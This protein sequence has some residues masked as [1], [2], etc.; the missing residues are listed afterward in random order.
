[1]LATSL[2]LQNSGQAKQY[3]TGATLARHKSPDRHNSHSTLSLTAAASR[4]YVTPRATQT[5]LPHIIATQGRK[6][7]FS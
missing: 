7:E 6:F 4:Q 3:C 2:T 1:M 5:P